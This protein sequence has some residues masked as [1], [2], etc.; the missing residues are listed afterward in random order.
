MLKTFQSFDFGSTLMMVIS[1]IR[2]LRFNNCSVI[3]TGGHSTKKKTGFQNLTIYI[4]ISKTYLI[5]NLI[6][7]RKE[8]YLVVGM[9]FVHNTNK[10][11]KTYHAP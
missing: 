6:P 1:E 9:V 4:Y 3:Q 8:I 2:Y 7:T 10:T 5:G 11:K